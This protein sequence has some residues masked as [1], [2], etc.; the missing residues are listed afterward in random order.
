MQASIERLAKFYESWHTAEPCK[1]YD[2]KAAEW[3][4]NLL[5][6]DDGTDEPRP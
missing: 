3:R 4:A 5:A 2:A 1:G 6:K